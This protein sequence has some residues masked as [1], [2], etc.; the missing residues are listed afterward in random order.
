M[1]MGIDKKRISLS[2]QRRDYAQIC[3][4][5]GAENDGL[6]GAIVGCDILLQFTM[7]RMVTR[8]HTRCGRAHAKALRRFLRGADTFGTE[9]H[10][11]IAVRAKQE[12]NL[13][14]NDGLNRAED[15]FNHETE[16]IN[17]VSGQSLEGRTEGT[18][19]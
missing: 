6:F 17:P 14:A 19:P 9:I 16:R 15:V 18:S 2:H 11:Q 8:S 5:S 13:A 4:E 10:S 12:G 1:T 3:H 7:K